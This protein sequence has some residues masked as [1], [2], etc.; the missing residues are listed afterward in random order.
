M[1]KK[2]GYSRYEENFPGADI[3]AEEW[4]FVSA[5]EK[6]RKETGRRHL[7]WREVLGVLLSLGYRKVDPPRE[8]RKPAE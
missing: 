5:I 3:T 2:I 7:A 6:Y 1:P 4:D 8:P